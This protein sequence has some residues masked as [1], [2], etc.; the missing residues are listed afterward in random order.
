MIPIHRMFMVIMLFCSYP[1]TAH[2]QTGVDS[3]ASLYHQYCA[4]CHGHDGSGNGPVASSLKAKPPN[5]TTISARREGDFPR[6]EIAG[7]IA[8]DTMPPIHGTRLMPI[9]GE[10]LQKDVI[11]TANKTAIA[12]GRISFLIDYLITIQNGEKQKTREVIT[13]TG[14]WPFEK[15]IPH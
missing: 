9:W 7:I 4:S 15:H 10:Q 3:G 8:G 14:G 13:P 11:G 6:H 12:H 2:S 1:M 5:L